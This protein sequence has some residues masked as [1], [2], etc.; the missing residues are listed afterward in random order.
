MSSFLVS[1]EE[2]KNFV[3][4]PTLYKQQ[5][6]YFAYSA[7]PETI[8]KIV[9]PPL[10]PLAPVI[11]GY[12]VQFSETNFGGPYMESAVC[13]PCKYKD[14]VGGYAYNLML[15]G[16]GAE[17][18]TIVGSNCCG[19]PKKTADSIEVSRIDDFVTARIS[20]HGVTLL[21]CEIQLGKYNDKSASD[22]L[23]DP[24]PGSVNPGASFFHTFNMLQTENGNTVFSDVNLVKLVTRSKCSSW[25]PGFLS[26]STKSSPDDPFGE[27]EVL[28]P[29]GGAYF[30][31]EYVEMTK[32]VKIAQL[33][34]DKTMP[35]LM[36][37]RY[38]RSMMGYRSTF[39]KGYHSA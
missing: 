6:V 24:V 28:K 7:P 31:N 3:N 17:S 26:I 9:P 19:I 37:G 4:V 27:L 33:D 5:G 20:R 21:E 39:L 32:T 12:V 10:E 8:A 25:E 23:G 35:Y 16:H 29:L 18:G 13:T 22:F 38:D 11:I 30:E 15:H 1:E 36:T 34:T 14:E 2:V